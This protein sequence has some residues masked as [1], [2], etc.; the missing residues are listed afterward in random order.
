MKHLYKLSLILVAIATYAFLTYGIERSTGS[1][2]GKTGSPGDNGATC[3]DCHSGEATQQDGLISSDIPENGFVPGE[4]YTITAEISDDE[5]E[6]I[7]FELTAEDNLENKV[8]DFTITNNTETQFTNSEQAVTHT[9]DGIEPS[10]NSN[11]WSFDWTAPEEPESAVTF[12]AAFNAADGNGGTSGDDIYTSEMTVQI[13]NVGI[14][15]KESITK[16]Y[17]NPAKEYL[18]VE[19][20]QATSR[21]VEILNTQGAVVKSL[22]STEEKITIP[23]QGLKTGV[24]FLKEGNTSLKR[25]VVM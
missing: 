21:E 13:N 5:A 25:F 2:G 7:G 6:L 12:Y 16:M 22:T 10:G 14:T 9:S 15:E 17:P 1:P 3:T 8:G 20:K 19:F 4:T 23:L 11:D 24:Y 18:K